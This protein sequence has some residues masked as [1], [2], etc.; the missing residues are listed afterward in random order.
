MFTRLVFLFSIV[1]Q[2]IA[3]SL[4]SNPMTTVIPKPHMTILPTDI[5]YESIPKNAMLYHPEPHYLR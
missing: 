2:S 5:H 1:V 4:R 3:L